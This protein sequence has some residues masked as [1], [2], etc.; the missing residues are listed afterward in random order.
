MTGYE[1]VE[2]CEGDFGWDLD[3][4]SLFGVEPDVR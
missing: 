4:I 3:E 1:V 2:L